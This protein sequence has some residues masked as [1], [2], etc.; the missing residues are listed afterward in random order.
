MTRDLSCTVLGRLATTLSDGRGCGGRDGRGGKVTGIGSPGKK[1]LIVVFAASRVA[2]GGNKARER[3]KGAAFR[4][5]AV[6]ALL[7]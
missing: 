5:I 4:L 7:L 3:K 6:V 1:G 2:D